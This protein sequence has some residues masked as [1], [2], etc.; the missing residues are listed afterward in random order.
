MEKKYVKNY[1][2]F[3]ND[4]AEPVNEE[5]LGAIVNF[6]KGLWKKAAA[7][8][9][10]IGDDWQAQVKYKEEVLFDPTDVDGIWGPIWKEYNAKPQFNDQ[11]CFDLISK[12]VDPDDSPMSQ[13]S[14]QEF[15]LQ[16]PEDMRKE[17]QVAWELVRNRGLAYFQYGG[18]VAK[19]WVPLQ[20]LATP[21]IKPDLK[22]GK[23]IQR[24]PDNKGFVDQTHL[25]L[26]KKVIAPL[27]DDKKKGA[28]IN[29]VKTVFVPKMIEINGALTEDEVKKYSGGDKQDANIF[30]TYGVKDEKELVGKDVYYKMEAFDPKAPK[31]EAIGKANVQS[32]DENK[33]LLLKTEKGTQFYKD[34]DSVLSKVEAEK[35]LGI[36]AGE[37]EAMN[38]ETL[39]K[40]FGEGKEVIFLLPGVDKAK[41]DPKKSA[42]EQKEVVGTGKMKALNDQN[43]EDSVTFDHE[44]KEIKMGYGQVIGEPSAQQENADAAEAAKELGEIKNDPE[45]MKRVANYAKFLKDARPEDVEALDDLMK[46]K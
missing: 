45:K 25:P 3:R 22:T 38:Y 8:I 2:S 23:A 19:A 12:M 5:L 36:K 33:G 43:K 29:W 26:L 4:K 28:V 39:N 9:K 13:K 6:L 41:Y 46:G 10:Q 44:G 16:L 32:F 31:K 34:A 30:A 1:E 42:E 21:S 35:I 27:T 17:E 14:I 7:K 20:K 37:G 40:I 15:I 18:T 24:T 11:D